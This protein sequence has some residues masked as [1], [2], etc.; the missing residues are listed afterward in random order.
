MPERWKPAHFAQVDPSDRPMF[1]LRRYMVAI[2]SLSQP[3]MSNNA[4]LS[5]V[6]SLDWRY[7]V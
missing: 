1:S 4:M 6:F 7:R 3:S 5:L 2:P